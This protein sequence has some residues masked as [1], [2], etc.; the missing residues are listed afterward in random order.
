VTDRADPIL[1]IAPDLVPPLVICCFFATRSLC[2]AAESHL[3]DDRI[4]LLK[5]QSQSDFLRLLEQESQQ[6]DCL[7]LQESPALLGLISWL[8]D[9]AILLP[10]VIIQAGEAPSVESEE[11]LD[12]NEAMSL[13][14]TAEVRLPIASLKQ[15][16]SVVENAIA[17]FLYLSPSCRLPAASSPSALIT[18]L[19]TQNFLLL[20]QRRLSDK[21]KERLGYMGV[22]YKRHPSF[23]LRNLSNQDQQET[24]LDLKKRYRTIVLG[25]FN[26][27]S[28]INQKI[29]SYV[30]AAFFA[31]IPVSQAVEIHM[32]IMDDFAKQLKLEGRNEEVVLD[33]RLT[34]IDTLAHLCEMYR[35]SIPK[36][37]PDP[38]L[39]F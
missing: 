6:I 30:D 18:D 2:A 3:P 4:I 9:H 14:H 34:L 22:Y 29:D 27:D 10:T 20:Q 11:L 15:L 19:S 31:D 16:E 37:T 13:Y 25:Y 24:L 7:I 38:L 1:S 35:R 32:E 23:F 17:Q 12:Q 21:L 8:N 26:S 33:Y 28:E 5:P 36:D 39:E